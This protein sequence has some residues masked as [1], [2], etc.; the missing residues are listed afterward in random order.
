MKIIEF[1]PVP[2]V[3]TKWERRATVQEGRKF[4]SAERLASGFDQPR[5][6]AAFRVS[7]LSGDRN[8]AGYMEM[9]RHVT[10]YGAQLIQVKSPPVNWWLDAAQET[11]FVSGPL[12]WETSASDPLAW[13]TSASNPLQWYS[14]YGQTGTPGTDALGYDTITVTGLPPLTQ[15]VRP[16]GVVK[17]YPS[18]SDPVTARAI[19]V[20]STDASGAVTVRLDAAL[21]AGVIS[22]GDFET[23]V[24][25]VDGDFPS[26]DQPLHGNWFLPINLKEVLPTEYAGATLVSPW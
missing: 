21:P 24:F 19:T 22:F 11:G 23:R 26:V 7:A 17:S 10:D 12:S 25:K 2:Y 18:G 3:A 1:P 20:A 4:F 16:A 9:L 13:E 15:V 14:G 8:A 5:V 6:F